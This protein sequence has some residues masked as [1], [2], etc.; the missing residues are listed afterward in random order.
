MTEPAL[1]LGQPIQLGVNDWYI[2]A[3]ATTSTVLMVREGTVGEI[4]GSAPGAA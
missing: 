1:T 4:G 3:A 2:T